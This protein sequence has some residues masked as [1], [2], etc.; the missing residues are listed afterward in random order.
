LEGSS[1]WSDGWRLS[2]IRGRSGWLVLTGVAF[3][4]HAVFGNFELGTWSGGLC[5]RR[6]SGVRMI[7]GILE[8]F[9]R[10]RVLPWQTTSP[11]P[12][13]RAIEVTSE[14]ER[15]AGRGV[16]I[17]LRT[18][19]MVLVGVFSSGIAEV[20]RTFETCCMVR[21]RTTSDCPRWLTTVCSHAEWHF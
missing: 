1:G 3:G 17:D 6:T 7:S 2:R 15:I 10:V 9:N 16:P 13:T 5:V 20:Q 12:T 14:S 4:M 8:R 11:C 19:L 21:T 18:T